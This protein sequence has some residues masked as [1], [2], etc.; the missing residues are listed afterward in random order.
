[1]AGIP[2][3][4]DRTHDRGREFSGSQSV[5]SNR[6]CG[7]TRIFFRRNREPWAVQI[8][9]VVQPIRGNIRHCSDHIRW[10]HD[11][12][13]GPSG[14]VDPSGGWLSAGAGEQFADPKPQE[15]TIY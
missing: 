6:E 12:I 4:I 2:A 7:E 3:K 1:M 5:Q 11:L 13:E 14:H 9:L 8:E 10:L 15:K